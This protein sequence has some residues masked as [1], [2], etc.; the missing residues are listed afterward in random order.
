MVYEG[1]TRMHTAAGRYLNEEFLAKEK[2]LQL[3]L[4]EWD[5]Y[6]FR[7]AV[8][9][10]ASFFLLHYDKDRLISIHPLVNAW[11]RDRLW[12][13]DEE[14]IWTQT[15]S[16]VA[17]SI[18]W[19]FQTAVYRFRQCLVPHIDECTKFR[20]DGVFHLEIIEGDC[21]KTASNFA[22]VYREAG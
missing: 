15:T 8:E 3:Q 16:T 13:S 9:V 21:L 19:T 2:A 5:I 6:P 14:V 18:P 7:V 22:L 12:P 20:N 1:C 4:E 17:L 10:L 11:A